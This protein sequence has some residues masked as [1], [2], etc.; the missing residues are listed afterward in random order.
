MRTNTRPV[1]FACMHWWRWFLF[2]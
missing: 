2:Q 1:S